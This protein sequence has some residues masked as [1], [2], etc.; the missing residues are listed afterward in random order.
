[1]FCQTTFSSV[2][3]KREARVVSYAEAF[4]FMFF[5]FLMLLLTLF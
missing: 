1:M 2:L 3:E 5:F 4:F